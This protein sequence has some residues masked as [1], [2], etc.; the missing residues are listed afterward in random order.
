MTYNIDQIFEFLSWKNC[1]ELQQKGITEASKIK[2]LSVL[3]MP[4]ENKSIWDNCAKVL[5]SKS[6]QDLKKYFFK[7]FEW[8]KDMNWPGAYTI[9]DRLIN[10]SDPQLIDEYKFNLETAVRMKD[11]AWEQSLNDFYIDY[12]MNLISNNKSIE[13]QKRGICLAR[14][15][16]NL[17]RFLRPEF[18]EENIKIWDN[19]AIILAERSDEELLPYLIDLF[20]WLKDLSWPGAVCI[21]QRLRKYKDQETF[22]IAYSSCMKCA[23]ALK[24]RN[25]Q[26]NLKEIYNKNII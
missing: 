14:D 3:I 2:N 7:L 6:D 22:N 8:L 18:S 4:I 1:N 23:K 13:D 12:V 19:C 24:D 25:W 20:K 10:V 15:I 16:K 17:T 21:L 5:C 11:V 26:R 9:Y